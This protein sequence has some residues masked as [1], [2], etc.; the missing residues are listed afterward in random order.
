MGRVTG[1][2]F[3]TFIGKVG[4]VVGYIRL[5]IPFV[6]K[7]PKKSKKPRT[8]GQR[9]V[10]RKFELVRKFISDTR[11][12]INV[13]FR[14]AA[15]GTGKTAQNVASSWNLKR[16]IDGVHPK[17]K[18]DYSQVL[19]SKG[20]L[21]IPMEV[22][23]VYVY[24]NLKYKWRVDVDQEFK[25]ERDQ[26]MMLAYHPKKARSFSCLSG[27]RRKFGEDELCVINLS[28]PRQVSA[29][30]DFVETYI[31]FISDD[32]NAISDSVYTGRVYL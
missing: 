22:V 18:L 16:A 14:V 5:G 8:L 11:G 29:D 6:R 19:L 26:V 20:N 17:L 32:R 2:A 23:V 25:Y 31:A 15:L 7:A 13:G 1:G 4:D 9:E 24:P 28:D 3:G 21:P 12:F 27:N 10:N 30:D